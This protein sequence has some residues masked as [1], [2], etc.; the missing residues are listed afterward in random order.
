MPSSEFLSKQSHSREVLDNEE[1]Q[2]DEAERVGRRNK[3]EDME[4]GR[5]REG[6]YLCQ[7]SERA[8]GGQASLLLLDGLPCSVWVGR[9]GHTRAAFLFLLSVPRHCWPRETFFYRRQ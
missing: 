3:E 1:G 2:L 5:E 6:S 9:W 8:E 4:G 7:F